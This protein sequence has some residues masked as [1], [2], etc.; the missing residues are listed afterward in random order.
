MRLA[1][2]TFCIG[3]LCTGTAQGAPCGLK[4]VQWMSGTWR[5]DSAERQTEERWVAG[6]DGVLFGSSWTMTPGKP[7]FIESMII[8][9]FDNQP[10]LR[11]RHFAR[12]L[13]HSM[14]DTD[15]PM[16]FKLA[17]CRT[18]LAVFEGQ[19]AKLGERITY[20]RDGDQ[21]RFTGDFLR[22]GKPFQVIVSFRRSAG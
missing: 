6:P 8:G 22:D 19:G 4:D 20:E 14:E 10:G 18:Q 9:R 21:L 11:L 2:S 7:A 12:D 15:A 1:I 13:E 3:V 16:L 5:S 17:T